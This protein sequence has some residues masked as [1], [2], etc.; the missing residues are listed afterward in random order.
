MIRQFKPICVH[1]V[2]FMLQYTCSYKMQQN[3]TKI[4]SARAK[5]SVHKMKRNNKTKEQLRPESQ[6][7]IFIRLINEL[8]KKATEKQL[9]RLYHF[10]KSYLD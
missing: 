4:A 3:N 2:K 5:R 6:K 9:K 7:E 8:L 10:I 1:D